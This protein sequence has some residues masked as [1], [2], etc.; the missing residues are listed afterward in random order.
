MR[1]IPRV[2]AAQFR[3]LRLGGG[4]QGEKEQDQRGT[5][6]RLMAHSLTSR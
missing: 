2:E 1:P 3:H 4:G 6:P 5:H